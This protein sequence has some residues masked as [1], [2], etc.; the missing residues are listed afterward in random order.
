MRV[1]RLVPAALPGILLLA[2]TPGSS[3][4]Q[5]PPITEVAVGLAAHVSTMGLGGDVAL[6]FGNRLGLRGRVAFQPYDPTAT[7]DNQVDLTVDMDSPTFAALVDVFPTG[8]GLRAT[9][10]LVRFNDGFGITAELS[11]PVEFN[12]T[13]YDPSEVGSVFGFV[14]G[15]KTAPYLGIGW[16]NAALSGPVGFTVDLGVAFYG[17]PNVSLDAEGPFADDP[18]FRANLE[19]ERAE[20]E[21]DLDGYRYYP[22]LSVGVTVG[23]YR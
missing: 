14:S 18:T 23:V 16:G 3:A 2:T 7:W 11:E 22:V 15:K 13:T 4:A 6:S 10:G 5:S 17:S 20:L 21:A 19:A 8:G 1:T 12:G 9:G